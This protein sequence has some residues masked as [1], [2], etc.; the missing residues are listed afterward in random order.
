MRFFWFLLWFTAVVLGSLAFL[1]HR[2]SFIQSLEERCLFGNDV[3]R[4]LSSKR[5][6]AIPRP[7]LPFCRL[8]FILMQQRSYVAQHVFL[9]HRAFM[10]FVGGIGLVLIVA[11]AISDRYNLKLYFAEGHNDKLM[12]NLGKS[13]KLIFWQF[14]PAISLWARSLCG[15]RACR[16]LMLSAIRTAALATGG[17]SGLRAPAIVYFQGVR[18]PVS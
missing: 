6:R 13:A 10:Q 2:D 17:F 15:W 16:H 11:G 18:R 12:P 8:A 7:A 1:F 3:F 9:L 4:M 14:M 5:C